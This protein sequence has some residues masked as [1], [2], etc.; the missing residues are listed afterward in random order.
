MACTRPLDAYKKVGGGITF[1]AVDG[2]RDRH[3]QIKCGQ[4]LGCRLERSRNWAIRCMHESQMHDTNSFLTLTYDE[5]HLPKNSSLDVRHWQLF[6][7]RARKRVGPFRFLHCGEYGD[8]NRRPHYHAC[9]F[10]QD[11]SED[12]SFWKTTPNGDH[13]FT[14]STLEELWGMG[15]A[16]IGALTFDSAAYVAA[17]TMKKVNGEKSEEHYANVDKDTGEYFGQLTPEYATMSRTPGI[18]A[19]WFEKYVDEVYPDDYVVAKGQK[20]RPP[21]YYDDMLDKTNPQ[22]MES[23]RKKRF[24]H[25]RKHAKDRTAQRLKVIEKVREAKTELH[26][27]D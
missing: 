11:F 7:K 22:L 15:Y 14:S 12:R 16:V 17:Y 27:H 9:V 1:K 5:E 2:Y 24:E 13:L 19:S 20:F 4:C 10:G 3:L 6:A 23:V 21:K 25:V 8:E 26:K 18:G